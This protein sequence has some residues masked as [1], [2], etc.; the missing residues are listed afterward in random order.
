MW[1]QQFIHLKAEATAVPGWGALIQ[2]A[3]L[4]WMIAILVFHSGGKRL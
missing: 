4:R 3:T 2:E 1:F